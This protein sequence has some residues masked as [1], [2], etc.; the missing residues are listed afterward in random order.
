MSTILK[1][2]Q[3]AVDELPSEQANNLLRY[4]KDGIY[5]AL[6]AP[7]NL[8]TQYVSS[9]TGNDANDGSR[10]AP[11]KTLARA[12]ERLPDG[13][14]GYI[15][16]Y[17][18]DT[19]PFRTTTD[20]TTWGTTVSYFGSQVSTGTRSIQIGPY[21]PRHDYY[22]RIGIGSTLFQGWLLNEEPKPIIEFGHYMYNGT[23]VGCSMY[24][25]AYSGQSVYIHGCDIRITEA[26]RAA[27]ASTNTAWSSL[28]IYSLFLG[29]AAHFRGC[30]FPD[31]IVVGNTTTKVVI[32]YQEIEV[33]QCAINSGSSQ[34]FAVE[35]TATVD[36]NDSGPTV[37]DG[38]GT[39]WPS[40][41]N[42]VS[43]NIAART[44]GIV[45][46]SKGIARNVFSGVIF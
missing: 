2:T 46:D 8:S 33:W 29:I 20:P 27:C 22:N 24:M 19:F 4:N 13:T 30:K 17:E 18:T 35:G 42:T 7:P 15:W 26:A 44:G 6:A 16:L 11:L 1:G 10:G 38:S 12:I 39:G 14:T 9:S 32:T 36:I 21:G 23:P 28:G 3:I 40:Q 5:F 34:W 41:S 31:P 25:G 43:N 45:K 37:Y